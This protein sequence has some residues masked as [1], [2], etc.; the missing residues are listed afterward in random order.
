MYPERAKGSNCPLEMSHN[1]ASSSQKY[2]DLEYTLVGEA[3]S[4]TRAGE[5]Y[6]RES[7]MGSPEVCAGEELQRSC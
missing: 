3:T 6:I 7:Y 4:E 5:G 1:L 2:A